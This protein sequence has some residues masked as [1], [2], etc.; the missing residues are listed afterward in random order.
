[1]SEKK[2]DII[3]INETKPKNHTRQLEEVE[4]K[5]PDYN[6]E[7]NKKL[8]PKDTGRGI[9]MYFH[10]SIVYNPIKIFQDRS[11]F[12]VELLTCE[13]K[14][15]DGEKLLLSNVYRSGSSTNSSNLRFFKAMKAISKLK[16]K[17]VLYVGDFNFPEIKWN[18][19]TTPCEKSLQFKFLESIRDC[20]LTQH[21]DS[22]TRGRGTNTPSILD[23]VLSSQDDAV[24]NIHI[25]SP[26]GSSDHSV[27]HIDYRCVPALEPDKI[28][29]M[30]KK[31]DYKKMIEMLDLNWDELFQDHLED[32][33]QLWDIFA[34]KYAEAESVCVP[35]K[36]VKSGTKRFTVPLDRKTLAKKRKKYRLWKRYLETREGEIYSE[37]R[38]CSNQL[39]RLTRKAAKIC[40]QRIASNSKGNPK[41]FFK[42]VNSK[43]KLRPA[44]PDLYLSDD[45]PNKENMTSNDTDKANVF[46]A[47]FS[48]VQT[49]EPDGAWLL[50]D[51]PEIKKELILNIT[52]DAIRE[53]LNKLKINKSPGPDSMHP[54]VL[55]EVREALVKPFTT[56]FKC[57]VRT[58]T[59]PGPWKDANIT[60]IHKKGDKHVAGNYRPVSLTS[61]ACKL[62]ESLIRDAL[63]KYMKENKLI[64][65]KQFGFLK[66]RST[67]LQLLKVLDRWTEILDRGGC[68]DVIYC[69]FKK[70]FDT[71]PHRRL[72]SVLEYYGVTG[73][74]LSWIRGFLSDRR[75]RVLVN[76]KDSEWHSVISGIPQGS[77]LGPV[78]FVVYINT[79]V[80]K[81]TKSEIFLF[82]D[83]AKVFNAI[84]QEPDT[85]SLQKDLD[86]MVDWTDDSRLQFHPGKCKS[87]R[88]SGGR[89]ELPE[90]NH[91]Y[92]MKGQLL[93][94]SS[95]EKDLGVIIDSKLSFDQHIT[96]KVKIGNRMAG[97]IRRS[98]E[99]MDKVMFKQLFTSMVRPHLEY[100]AVVWNPHL[101]KH[102]TAL[103]NVQRRATKMV[104]GLVDK[105]GHRLP[106]KDRLKALKL[107]TLAYRR[108]RGDM[109][110]MFKL[111][112]N[113]YD[114]D[115]SDDF[116]E[117][118]ASRARG[119]PY[120][121]HKG[122]MCKGL[123]VRKYSFKVRVT[124][125]WNNLPEK[126]VMS[127]TPD[128]FK[129]RL[130]KIWYGT[131][132]YFNE[133]TNVLTKT[134]ARNTRRAHLAHKD[135]MLEA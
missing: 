29:Y 62:L 56:I 21:V 23:L 55:H 98:F 58:G 41:I 89:T 7:H 6:M 43:T 92:Y 91:D 116:L 133:E 78:L 44:V 3:T 84:S 125:Q 32:V 47:F 131:D 72:M 95:D 90:I 19:L 100:A 53:K 94:H 87:M 52:E 64:S 88:I 24:E 134:S 127:T 75:Q 117:L 2:P 31:A 61:V 57:S 114:E 124:E 13:V 112:H 9:F 77:V 122:R 107:P 128:M 49:R 108:Y 39:R 130:D 129:N 118:E 68:V 14:L 93:E 135:L 5:I 115:V 73:P 70:A 132:V 123:D 119:H 104:P 22:V 33:N 18:C 79:M 1:M 126:V 42:Y 48:S 65:R 109:I 8:G 63:L 67:V 60:A 113:L 20:Y 35:K 51:K 99:Y 76:G 40:E 59:L 26:L 85:N 54:R 81:D 17:H 80:E 4:Y 46:A 106:Y 27:M 16:Y 121:V 66:G 37:Y 69:D 11:E 34:K 74:T 120:N 25:D 110:E 10:K 111:T 36:V 50:P 38:K 105:R 86:D 28:V 71:V 103:E 97:L 82:A 45:E 101:Q 15:A 96:E 102:I 83:D 12:P 30:Y